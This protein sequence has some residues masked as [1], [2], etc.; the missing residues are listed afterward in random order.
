MNFLC[1]CSLIAEEKLYHF[2]TQNHFDAN[3]SRIDIAVLLRQ[4]DHIAPMRGDRKSQSWS[5]LS[6]ASFVAAGWWT[7]QES[8]V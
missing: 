2:N 8:D 1:L 7:I 3:F 4:N 6:L 5:L